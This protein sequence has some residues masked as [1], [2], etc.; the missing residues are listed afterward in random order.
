MVISYVCLQIAA[1]RLLEWIKECTCNSGKPNFDA[2]VFNTNYSRMEI[3]CGKCRGVI[4]WW[5]LNIEQIATLD[6]SKNK[7]KP[8]PRG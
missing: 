2:I 8:T 7:V 4:C 6:E 3:V 5:P 1:K